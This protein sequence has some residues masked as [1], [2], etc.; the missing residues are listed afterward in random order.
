MNFRTEFANK[1]NKLRSDRHLTVRELAS[2][3]G[4]HSSLISALQTESRVIGEHNARKIGEAL[5][6]RGK[7]LE[8][9]V[10][11]AINS[12]SERV[13]DQFKS[14]PAEVL[15]LITGKLAELGVTAEKI[16]GCV[17]CPGGSLGT[18]VALRLIDGTAATINVEV[19]LQ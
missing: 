1:L 17:L 19:A 13:L 9:F 12:C 8:E 5:D 6:L 2:R 16:A 11:L 18:G 10:Y 7:E 3:A 4:V 14:Y 15:N